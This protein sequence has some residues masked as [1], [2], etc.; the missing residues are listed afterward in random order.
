MMAFLRLSTYKDNK[1]SQLWCSSL[2][3]VRFILLASSG[4]EVDF[5][6]LLLLLLLLLL[7]VMQVKVNYNLLWEQKYLYTCKYI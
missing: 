7:Q 5:R 4:D 2:S 1:C 3:T 6:L